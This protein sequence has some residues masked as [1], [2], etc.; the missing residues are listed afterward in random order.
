MFSSKFTWVLSAKDLKP[1]MS[2]DFSRTVSVFVKGANITDAVEVG[3]RV[4]VGVGW[5]GL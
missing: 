2:K 4:S 5:V 1:F 3:R